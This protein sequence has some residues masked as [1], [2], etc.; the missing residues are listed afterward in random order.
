MDIVKG[1]WDAGRTYLGRDE[2]RKGSTSDVAHLVTT[3]L[4]SIQTISPALALP[5]HGLAI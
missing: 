3:A 1:D 4:G 2:S 5:I